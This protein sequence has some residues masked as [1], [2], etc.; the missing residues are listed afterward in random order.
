MRTF[1]TST[2]FST[3]EDGRLKNED[4][5]SERAATQLNDDPFQL[6]AHAKA[7]LER[8]GMLAPLVVTWEYR[9]PDAQAFCGW[10]TTKDIL[11]N[12]ARLA[13]DAKLSGM[14][15]GGTYRVTT[16]DERMGDKGA[17]EEN[18]PRFRTIWGYTTR[19]A[20]EDMHT[21]CSRKYEDASIIQID[22]VEFVHGLK[23]FVSAAG[24][25]HFRQDIL[26]SSA[27]GSA[28]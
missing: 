4:N 7:L 27:A 20:M 5:P 25:E 28:S 18:V 11:L 6:S 9:V 1:P 10:L 3:Q 21:L 8:R 19:S 12:E 14:S 17:Q 15:Y 23:R 2:L 22:L 16:L 24:D 13:S 26:I